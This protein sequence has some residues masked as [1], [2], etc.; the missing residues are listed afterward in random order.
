[1]RNDTT[2]SQENTPIS[3][4]M[5]A[6]IYSCTNDHDWIGDWSFQPEEADWVGYD[7][8]EAS[9]KQQDLEELRRPM[10]KK[11]IFEQ[12]LIE[13]LKNKIDDSTP[14]GPQTSTKERAA[15]LISSAVK[16]LRDI[17]NLKI[18]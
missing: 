1:M 13:S 11:L 16:H 7:L 4:L 15:R 3:P 14:E 2:T 5:W 17:G 6:N 8:N 10:P 9:R 12:Q 18:I